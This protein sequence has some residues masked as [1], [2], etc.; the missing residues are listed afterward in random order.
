MH[1]GSSQHACMHDVDTL[2]L[3]AFRKLNP[4][5]CLINIQSIKHFNNVI[6]RK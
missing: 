3:L 4:M 5:H 6:D 2:G 1:F